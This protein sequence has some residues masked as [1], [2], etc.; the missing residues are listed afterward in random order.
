MAAI[1]EASVRPW[2]QARLEEERAAWLATKAGSHS[3]EVRKWTG[4]VKQAADKAVNDL[5]W[6]TFLDVD[7]IPA[8]MQAGAPGIFDQLAK[9][10]RVQ[11]AEIVEVTDKLGFVILPFQ[12]LAKKSYE[13]ESSAMRGAIERFAALDGQLD[14]Y[15]ACPAMYYNLDQHIEAADPNRQIFAGRND[16]AF[17]ALGLTLPTLRGMRAQIDTMKA[18]QREMER[19]QREMQR[20]IE[21]N[22]RNIAQLAASVTQMR[23][24]FTAR[25]DQMQ[26][27]ING[28]LRDTVERAV[29]T[30][31]TIQ[32]A[33]GDVS[34][35]L[36]Q[37]KGATNLVDAKAISKRMDEVSFQ[38]LEPLMFAL[39]P[40]TRLRDRHATAILGP[41]WGPDF[42]DFIAT[43]VGLTVDKERRTRATQELTVWGCPGPVREKSLRELEQEKQ[44]R[45]RLYEWERESWG[46]PLGYPVRQYRGPG[47]GY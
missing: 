2:E 30:A 24:E 36:T 29:Q 40:G 41:C 27:T 45:E 7:Q 19:N 26:E 22:T 6:K 9:T 37:L 15:V 44:E 32:Q 10:P 17:M 5:R 23:T 14:V 38:L 16:Q 42:E 35:L 13:S 25:L 12:Y 1:P 20:M 34:A 43:A 47:S 31:H 39:K 33:G 4:E 11:L 18:T 3:S 28:Q 8:P 46:R 21:Q